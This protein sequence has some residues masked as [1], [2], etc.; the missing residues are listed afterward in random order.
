MKP[1]EKTAWEYRH[2]YLGRLADLSAYG[3]DGWECYAVIPTAGDMAIFYFKRR[4]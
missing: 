4:R 3:K 1:N 2:E